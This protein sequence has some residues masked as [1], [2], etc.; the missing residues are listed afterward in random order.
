MGT[1]G[2]SYYKAKIRRLK[3]GKNTA[4]A[5]RLSKLLI[6]FSGVDYSA[7][8]GELQTTYQALSKFFTG[9]SQASGVPVTKKLQQINQ[10]LAAILTL[11]EDHYN[12]TP[13]SPP[14]GA[15]DNHL[16]LM[17]LDAIAEVFHVEF[18]SDGKQHY[19]CPDTSEFPYM[20]TAHHF[21]CLGYADYILQGVYAM[22]GSAKKLKHPQSSGNDYNCFLDYVTAINGFLPDPD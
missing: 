9:A 1:S 12:L 16:L 13:F 21:A 10:L 8:N 19:A 22:V 2:I 5:N 17:Y 14:N 7:L 15:N 3:R 6:A 18:F 20:A 11:L 4:Q